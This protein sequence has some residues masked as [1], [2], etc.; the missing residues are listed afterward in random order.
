M[1]N[2]NDQQDPI[3]QARRQLQAIPISAQDQQ[4][5]HAQFATSIC[6]LMGAHHPDIVLKSC[7]VAAA[8]QAKS[9]GVTRTDF[10]TLAG[11]LFDAVEVQP[12]GA[13]LGV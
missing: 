4:R 12:T 10:R 7:M 1:S 8:I 2:N 3:Q 13:Q 6:A 11:Q 5:M 9:G